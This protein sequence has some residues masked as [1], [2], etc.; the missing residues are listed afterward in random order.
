VGELVH[1]GPTVALGYWQD[2]ESTAAKFRPHPFA[3]DSNERV[4]YSGDLVT[5]DEAGFLYFIGRGDEMIKSFGYRISPTEA[6]EVVF[7]SG[8]VSEVVVHGAPD[9]VAGQVVVA[10][11]VPGRPESFS[12]EELLGYCRREM[13]NYMVPKSIVVHQRFPRTAS[14]KIDRKAVVV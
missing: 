6:E 1:R 12:A 5:A 8:L 7:E 11:C 4:V 10:H 9:P 3:P 13:P 14:G 2:P